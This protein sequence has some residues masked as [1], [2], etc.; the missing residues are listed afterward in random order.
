MTPSIRTLQTEAELQSIGDAWRRCIRHAPRPHVRYLPEWLAIQ[1]RTGGGSG[2]ARAIRAGS[3]PRVIAA[4]DGD[5]LVG[6]A[7]LL[8]HQ[9][10]WRCRVGYLSLADFPVRRAVLCG[11][12]LLAPEDEGVAEAM[13]EAAARDDAYGVVFLECIPT[14]SFLFRLLGRSASIRA[15]FW[16]D[17]EARMP[18]RMI[19]LPASFEEYLGKFSAKTR[20]TLK[21]KVRK[22][23]KACGGKL[24]VEC[25]R[26]PS[27][28]DR[29]LERAERVSR[30]SWQGTRLDQV[31]QAETLGP[32]IRAFAEAGMLRS[33]VL[34][35]GEEPIAFVLG[36][37]AD[38]VYDYE[39]PAYDPAY[40]AHHPGTVLLYRLL[41]DLFAHDRPELFD[42]GYGENEY[43]RIFSNLTEDAANVMLVHKGASLAVPYGLHRA[44]RATSG[45]ARA[46]LDRFEL[47]ERVRH[48]LRGRAPSGAAAAGAAASP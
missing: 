32:R 47:R 21:Y 25:V 45:A 16:V 1:T 48:L 44:C 46:A 15:S 30:R 26:R 37:Q 34:S 3:Q 43:K 35:S 20:Q 4:Y 8:V 9:W 2:D 31:I 13:L 40:A 18:H 12:A 41:E 28:V 39:H 6:L 10:R 17:D 42:F 19:Q 23:E 24:S 29:F 11:D 7:P 33:Y 14:D 22:L 36:V 27:E 5:E 38:G